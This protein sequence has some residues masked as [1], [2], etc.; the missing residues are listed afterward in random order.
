MIAGLSWKR[1]VK[2]FKT[3]EYGTIEHNFEHKIAN[4]SFQVHSV[5][6]ISTPVH[7]YTSSSLRNLIF[8]SVHHINKL[9]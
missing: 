5:Q 6:F 3:S 8:T 9:Q 1:S 4:L 2:D 7:F